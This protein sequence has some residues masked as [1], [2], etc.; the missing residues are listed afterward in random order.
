MDSDDLLVKV[1][2]SAPAAIVIIVV[3]IVVRWWRRMGRVVGHEAGRRLL[4]ASGTS[5]RS[6]GGHS[7][8]VGLV[9]GGHRVALVVGILLDL[10]QR[11][12]Q[13]AKGRVGH[14][15]HGYRNGIMVR[16]D[17]GATFYGAR[18]R[19][20]R[21]AGHVG[22]GVVI[23]VVLGLVSLA[24]EQRDV[25]FL[26]HL[27]AVQ[28]LA[29]GFLAEGLRR[30][31]DGR[32]GHAGPLRLQVEHVVARLHALGT[33]G[34]VE[35]VQLNR[36]PQRV[37]LVL[38]LLVDFLLARVGGERRL[39]RVEPQQDVPRAGHLGAALVRVPLPMLHDVRE[40]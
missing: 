7:G 30:V 14:V 26:H 23:L 10:L 11:G 39:R 40:A 32:V 5:R 25:D 35:L 12:L 21:R 13:T 6:P 19:R 27:N 3:V 9:G 34:Q 17:A 28:H 20:R 2:N 1:H 36:T 15:V 4:S 18:R 37:L 24:G 33:L 16:K 8:R 29:Q 22:V 31:P 38:L